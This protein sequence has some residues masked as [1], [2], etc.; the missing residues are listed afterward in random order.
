MAFSISWSNLNDPWLNQWHLAINRPERAI[1]GVTLDAN[2]L[3]YSAYAVIIGCES[4]ILAVFTKVFAISEKLLPE[5]PMLN[6]GCRYINLEVG[7]VIGS[8]LLLSGL[9]C[10]IYAFGLLEVGCAYG[11]FLLEAQQHFECFGIEISE[12]AA[13]S[14]ASRGLKVL[15]GLVSSSSGFLRENGPFDAVAMLDV[16]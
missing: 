12:T 16:I 3:L 4:V 5:D 11:F 6:Q 7:L 14:C 8:T 1:H 15:Q 13:E 2:T 10:S 9:A